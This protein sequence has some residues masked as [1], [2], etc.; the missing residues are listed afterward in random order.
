M[1][2]DGFEWAVHEAVSGGEP[3]V[4]NPLHQALKKASSFVKDAAP[5]SLFFG[6]ERAKFLGFL[7]A[8][9]EEAGNEAFLLPEGSGRPFRFGPWVQLAAKGV[10]AE[11]ELNPRIKKIW[12]TDLFLSAEGD[13][14]HFATTVKSNFAL[15]EGGQGLRIGVVPESVLNRPGFRG[16]CLV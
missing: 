1:K 3:A 9:V 11:A 14:R 5:R 2:G 8:V 16:G 15:L 7:D 6:H 10:A 12:K 13:T 4:V